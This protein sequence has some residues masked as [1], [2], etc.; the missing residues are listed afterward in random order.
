METNEDFY[1]KVINESRF[2]DTDIKQPPPVITI[3]GKTILTAGNFITISGLPKSR[4]TTF[5]QFFIYSA[6]TQNVHFDIHVNIDPNNKIILIDT[7]Q[8]IYDFSRQTSYLKYLLRSKKLPDNFN[9]YLFRQYEPEVILNSI[10]LIVKEHRPKILFIDNLTELVLNP[11]DMA[12]SKKVIQFLKKITFEFDLC[13]VNLLH[14]SKSNNLTLGNLGSY[15]DR[16]AQS[17]LKVT[18]DKETQSSTLEPVMLRSDSFFNPITII[19]DQDKKDYINTDIEVKTKSSKKFI[20]KD[21]TDQDHYNRLGAIFATVTEL[22][23]NELVE[24]IKRIYGIGTNIAK[25]QI[26][27]YLNGNKFLTSIKGI[28]KPNYK[29]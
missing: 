24:E 15:A 5:M 8:S 19:Y 22:S 23:Y 2:I 14:L 12:E 13:I 11:N 3:Q 7:E 29:K 20:L 1:N 4:K 27:P 26:I 16:A 17:V 9:A 21:L 28:Y 10:Y 6:F 18:L 25:Q